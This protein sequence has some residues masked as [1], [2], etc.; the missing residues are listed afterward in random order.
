MCGCF[1][2]LIGVTLILTSTSEFG[3][4]LGFTLVG[5]SV[6]GSWAGR[7]GG[8]RTVFQSIPPRDDRYGRGGP[9]ADIFGG[10][11]QRQTESRQ[12]RSRGPVGLSSDGRAFFMLLGMVAKAD[13]RVTQTEIDALD[14][15]LPTESPQ[16][17]DAA[18]AAFRDGRDNPDQL[19][20]TVQRLFSGVG[21]GQVD[22]LFNLFCQLAIVDGAL[23]SGERAVLA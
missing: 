19:S 4:L 8:R 12:P 11:G 6:I 9:F 22:G 23:V 7:L 17:R 3:R 5:L 10:A 1:L 2:P 16:A 18:V 14:P 20:A 13:G 15:L 21:A